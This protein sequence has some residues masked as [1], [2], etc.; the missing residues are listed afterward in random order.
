MPMHHV[1]VKIGDLVKV[2]DLDTKTIVY[3]EIA[4][5]ED[6]SIVLPAGRYVVA[7]RGPKTMD[8]KRIAMGTDQEI[9]DKLEFLGG[10]QIGIMTRRGT[11]YKCSNK[12]CNF[13]TLDQNVIISHERSHKMRARETMAATKTLEKATEI[14]ETS[15]KAEQVPGSKSPTDHPP[16]IPSSSRDSAMSLTDALN[17]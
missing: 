8:T 10:R 6:V 9:A 12:D 11:R 17:E 14:L 1:K 16:E 7:L 2:R 13:T 4:K 3:H 15:K 5:V